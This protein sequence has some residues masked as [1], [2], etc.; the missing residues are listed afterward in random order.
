[1]RAL[2]T[3][4]AGLVGSEIVDLLL[5]N[6]HNVVSVD[7]YTAGKKANNRAASSNPNFESIEGDITDLKFLDELIGSGIDW[8]FHEAVSKNT[9]CLIDPNKDLE[10]NAGG[11]LKLLMAARKH[12]VSRFIHASTGSVYGPAKIF[13][14]NEQHRKDPASFYGVSKLAAESYVQLFHEFYGL[15][16]TILRYFH[17]FGARQDSSDVGG[18]VSIFLRRA[19]EGQD[20]QVTGDGSQLR[21]FTHVSDVARINLMAAES[22]SAV[23]QIYNCASD[24]RITIR[25]LAEAVVKCVNDSTSIIKFTEP[26]LGDIYKFDIDNQK[27]KSDLSFNFLT[28]FDI[29]LER[30]YQ[31][32][33]RNFHNTN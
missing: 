17:V 16:T 33:R 26:R 25:E 22:S 19:M 11:T 13:P 1:M 3:G 7:N 5:L 32:M 2:V 31:E 18:V 12:N 15:S 20:L 10:V 6:G 8:I 23:G 24:S 30:T 14:T 21:A 29:G 9:V 4:G 28:S 27:L